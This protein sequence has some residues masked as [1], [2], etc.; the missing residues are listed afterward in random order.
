MS[1]VQSAQGISN[2]TSIVGVGRA[3][4]QFATDV[5]N[6][7][8][9]QL[10]FADNFKAQIISVTF[11]AANTDMQINQNLNSVPSG[12]LVLR[13]SMSLDVYDGSQNVFTKSYVTL[14][15]TAPGT[16]SLMVF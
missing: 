1:T 12:Y 8:N 7:L 16:V 14:R 11:N 9:G 10:S 2:Q 5:Q 15:S 4:Q 13:K 3:T 6:L